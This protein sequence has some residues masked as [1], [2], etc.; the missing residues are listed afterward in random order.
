RRGACEAARP[1]TDPAPVAA[2]RECVKHEIVDRVV[3]DLA[4]PV[5]LDRERVLDRAVAQLFEPNHAE[6][7][8]KAGRRSGA[9]RVDLLD[10][11][12]VAKRRGPATEADLQRR[13]GWWQWALL[14]VPEA[15]HLVLRLI[16]DRH[17][18]IAAG[19]G[20]T[21]TVA[22]AASALAHRAGRDAN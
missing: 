20:P 19:V 10:L 4:L 15:E 9:P 6:R 11:R 18:A 22:S 1:R 17:V 5:D 7:V 8:A 16:V 2:R 14:D 12:A 21:I 13:A 3:P